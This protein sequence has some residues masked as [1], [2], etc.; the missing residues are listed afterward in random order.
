MEAKLQSQKLIHSRRKI[1]YTVNMPNTAS[2]GKSSSASWTRFHL[3]LSTKADRLPFLFGGADT[4][5]RLVDFISRVGY[6]GIR[7]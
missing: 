4:P 3:D 2:P 6:D 5:P 1:G 7:A